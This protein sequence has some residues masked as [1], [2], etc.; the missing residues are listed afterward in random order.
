MARTKGTEHSVIPSSSSSSRRSMCSSAVPAQCLRASPIRGSHGSRDKSRRAAGRVSPTSPRIPAQCP[1]VMLTCASCALVTTTPGV[2]SMSDQR[3]A[4]RHFLQII[5]QRPEGPAADWPAVGAACRHSW[6]CLAIVLPRV[7]SHCPT[8]PAQCIV[9]ARRNHAESGLG[10][11]GCRAAPVACGAGNEACPGARS[12]IARGP[13]SDCTTVSVTTPEAE[14]A[15]R[16]HAFNE[17][18]AHLETKESRPG[19]RCR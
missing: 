5:P 8:R 7:A 16:R 9:G 14:R 17:Q 1:G 12:A 11:R 18:L 2:V 19:A 15:Q 3:R 6:P 13:E 4:D 10:S